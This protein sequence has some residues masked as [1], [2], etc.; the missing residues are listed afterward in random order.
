MSRLAARSAPARAASPRR[1]RR[2]RWSWKA[3]RHRWSPRTGSGSGEA[4]AKAI[5]AAS[6]SFTVSS[7]APNSL[8]RQPADH[9]HVSLQP[10]DRVVGLFPRR[11]FLTGAILAGV[12][13]RVPVVAVGLGLDQGRPLAAA[14]ALDR[15][16]HRLAHGQH[17]H[18]I[19]HLAGDAVGAA[20]GRRCRAAWSH[21][22]HGTDMPYWLFSATKM[23]GRSQAP[24]MFS[25]SWKLP[26]FDAPSPKKQTT[27]RSVPLELLSQRRAHGHGQVAA[28]DAGGAQVAVLHV[29]D[30]HRAAL[31]LAVAV[32][33]AHAPRPSSCCSAPAWPRASCAALSPCACAWPCP[34]WV[35]VIRSSSRRADD[36][37]D[38]HGLF[39]GVEVR[40]A[41]EQT[42]W[43]AGPRCCSSSARISMIWRS[44]CQQVLTREGLFFDQCRDAGG[45]QGG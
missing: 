35:L 16:A 31:A 5:A 25:A 39:A 41:L 23:T 3:H 17:V 28:D 20:R 19:H 10:V 42:P 34:R 1:P 27:T 37:A 24:A 8:V 36:R 40:C 32:G 44:E 2:P 14:R 7:S 38:R 18:A 9:L 33:L 29:R 11:L 45:V 15:P 12:G 6:F 43:S 26:S 4:L 22:F 21:G 30:V 13:V